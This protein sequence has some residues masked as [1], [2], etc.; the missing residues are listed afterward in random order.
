MAASTFVALYAGISG[1]RGTYL[2]TALGLLGVEIVV[3]VGNGFRCSRLLLVVAR[4][5]GL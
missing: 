3:F 4:W 5:L 2:W 1:A